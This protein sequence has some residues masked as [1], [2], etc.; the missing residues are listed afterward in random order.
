[1][2]TTTLSWTLGVLA[3]VA[4]MLGVRTSGAQSTAAPGMPNSAHEAFR[5]STDK[6]PPNWGGPTFK[7]SR[8]YPKTLPTCDAPWLKRQ[9]SFSDP[10]PQWSPDWQAYVQDIVNYVKEGQD[11]DL[12]NDPG[13]KLAVNGQTRWFH[14]PWMAFDGERG[15]EFVHG[16]T[17]ELSTAAST[18]RNGGRGSGKHVLPGAA[19]VGDVD[20]LF[21]T[22]SVGMY[23]PCG[24]W[25]LGQLFPPS[26]VPA[27]YRQAGRTFARGLPFPEGTVV[28]KILTTTAS[29]STVPYLKGSPTWQA[30]GHV[31]SGP[32]DY[33]VCQRQVRDVHL[34]QIDLAVVD[35]RSPTRWVYS[36]L[37]YDGTLPGSTVWDRLRALGVQW[38]SDP[39]TFP[40]VP[41]TESHPPRETIL[42]PLGISEHYGCFKRLAGA[43]DQSN[44]S[45][46]SCH[47]GA[48]AAEPGALNQ[49]GG[50]IPAIF[51]F[52]DMCYQYNLANSQYFSDYAYP[53]AFPSGQFDEAIPLDSS[54]QVAVAFAQY[55]VF[56][57]P[58]S[59]QN[60]KVCPDPLGPENA[61]PR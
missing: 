34:V 16:L 43:V 10:N 12:A 40:A 8:D 9:V 11:D 5:D 21:E 23:N 53:S 36:T 26:G 39:G 50:N 61:T 57:N 35:P 32:T 46:V 51:S 13:W 45:C 1:M 38:G 19:R 22:W 30:D 33:A 20:P 28:M 17:N 4:L 44:S 48:Y 25:A 14:V 54:L 49:Q 60:S 47:M 59:P 3:A 31:Q 56:K 52:G 7:L 41:T 27:T 6:A 37:A 24:A 29:D 18:F 42:A 2:R 55:G 15:R 58:K